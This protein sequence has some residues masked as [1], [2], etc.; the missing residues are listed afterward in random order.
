MAA[1]SSE[2][3]SLCDV[4]GLDLIRPTIERSP[5]LIQCELC[6]RSI[7]RECFPGKGM[8]SLFVTS[9]F[10]FKLNFT[11]LI[12][13][14]TKT[15]FVKMKKDKEIFGYICSSV[16]CQNLPQARLSRQKPRGRGR[17][18]GRPSQKK[19]RAR[20]VSN[21]DSKISIYFITTKLLC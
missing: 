2:D 3:E 4:C 9:K 13:V 11:F 19:G 10:Y 1:E 7:H 18:R 5:Q 12:I 17:G 8:S 21:Y 14:I 20:A 6:N 16:K 15:D